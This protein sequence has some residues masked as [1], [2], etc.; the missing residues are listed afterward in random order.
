MKHWGFWGFVTSYWWKCRFLDNGGDKLRDWFRRSQPSLSENE[1]QRCRDVVSM[2]LMALRMARCADP[3]WEDFLQGSLDDVAKNRPSTFGTHAWHVDLMNRRKTF[4]KDMQIS[5]N[6]NGFWNMLYQR[7]WIQKRV[8]YVFYWYDVYQQNIARLTSQNSKNSELL[9]LGPGDSSIAERLW[10]TLK[11]CPWS[12]G[13]R[14]TRGV[15]L[16]EGITDDHTLGDAS[17]NWVTK[18]R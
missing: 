5:S 9:W 11:P 16:L 13:S 18:Y 2:K 6:R 15:M 7:N 1:Q 3:P 10:K 8:F 12:R 17:K 14:A 4:S